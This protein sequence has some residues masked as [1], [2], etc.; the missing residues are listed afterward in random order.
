MAL[1]IA[2]GWLLGLSVVILIGAITH[3]GEKHHILWV[4]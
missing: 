3:R 2:L 1:V 4:Q